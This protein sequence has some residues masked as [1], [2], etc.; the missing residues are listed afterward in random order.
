MVISLFW[1]QE[2][3]ARRRRVK[4]PSKEACALKAHSN[5]L[6]PTNNLNH[7]EEFQ[8]VTGGILALRF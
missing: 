7:L 8:I 2:V 3:G 4:Q 5:P 6:A 1:E